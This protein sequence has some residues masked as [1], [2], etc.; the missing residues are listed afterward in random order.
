MPISK[1]ISFDIWLCL[2]LEHNSI[3]E[4]RAIIISIVYSFVLFLQTNIPVWNTLKFWILSNLKFAHVAAKN[5]QILNTVHLVYSMRSSFR[6]F[7]T[8]FEFRFI[9][10][11]LI[12]HTHTT[13]N[14]NS[15]V[16]FFYCCCA[17]FWNRKSREC[18]MNCLSANHTFG[19]V[20]ACE[21]GKSLN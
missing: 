12:P 19:I 18:S 15:F 3:T 17:V 4:C 1:T 13:K 6:L 10:I 5:D 2:C 9:C 21:C 8:F 7:H 16:V 14:C 11:S 20:S